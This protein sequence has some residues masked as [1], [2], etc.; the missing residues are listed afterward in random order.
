MD[1]ESEALAVC[2][3]EG[4]P[5]WLSVC[6]PL[7]DAVC[8]GD[9]DKLALGDADGVTLPLDVPD[10]LDVSWADAVPVIDEDADLDWLGVEL[11][12][13]VTV[14]LGDPEDDARWLFVIE[15]LGVAEAL[16]VTVTLA[17]ALSLSVCVSLAVAEVRVV[18][19]GLSVALVLLVDVWEALMEDVPLRLL[20]CDEVPLLLQVAETLGVSVRLPVALALV[21]DVKLLLPDAVPLGLPVVEAL[22]V[23]DWL[24]VMLVLL[25]DV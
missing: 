10:A 24:P 1:W 4:D 13:S 3:R 22:G 5:V 16:G 6:V 17:V 23:F 2:E 12:D 14:S 8:E 21:V 7:G 11:W 18:P 19:D 9:V 15:G 20:V 25:V